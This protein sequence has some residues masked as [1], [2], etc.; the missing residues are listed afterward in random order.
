LSPPE[1]LDDALQM[2][3]ALAKS[4]DTSIAA[5]DEGDN[6]F[7]SVLSASLD[8]FLSGC[9]NLYKRLAEPKNDIFAINCLLA[10]KNVLSP[11]SFASDR[12]SEMDDTIREHSSKLVESQHRYLT[13]TSG[14]DVLLDA[15]SEVSDSPEAMTSL[16]SLEPFKPEHLIATSQQLDDFLPSALMDAAENIKRLSNSRMVQKI[17]EE[18]ADKFCE[19]F[20]F[21]E[22]RIIAAD[23]LV[24][25]GS[26]SED[27][28]VVR[29]R[30]IFPRTSG[31]IR[32][33]LS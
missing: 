2:L 22:S 26:D 24:D 23:A 4:Y 32:V 21:L 16:A 8:P 30:D 1:F 20:E 9:E 14:I 12:I 29:L 6:G 27:Q 25:D 11:Y 31:E 13:Y 15:M 33:L 28:V 10:A 5:A 17:T 19:D 7:Q 18:A 3:N